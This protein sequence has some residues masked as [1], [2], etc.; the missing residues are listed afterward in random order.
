MELMGGTYGGV[1]QPRGWASF[2][3]FSSFYSSS[4]ARRFF[5]MVFFCFFSSLLHRLLLLKSESAGE[6][7]MGVAC[8]ICLPFISLPVL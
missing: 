3:S 5:M 8:T 7:T 2:S 1:A 4:T 6:F